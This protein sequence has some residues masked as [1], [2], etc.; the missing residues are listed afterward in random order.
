MLGLCTVLRRQGGCHLS[1]T[2]VVH[3]HAA[4][5]SVYGWRRQASNK[6]AAGLGAAASRSEP[7]IREAAEQLKSRLRRPARLL[8]EQLRPH[9]E[10]GEQGQ[11]S[12]AEPDKEQAPAKKKFGSWF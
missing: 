2:V 9:E 5:S 12:D 7:Q 6:L 8:P 10:P 1:G 4:S 11:R 3:G